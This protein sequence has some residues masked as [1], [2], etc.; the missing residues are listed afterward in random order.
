M[1]RTLI[2]DIKA[3]K[4]RDPAARSYLEIVLCYSGLHAIL[5]HRVNHW[6]WTHGFKLLAR[7]GSQ[8]AKMF[9]GI[10]IHPGAKIGKGFFIDHGTGTVIGETA[11]I[12]DNVTLFHGVTLGGTGK[13][14]GK[15]H[16][17]VEDNV[18]VGA[19]AQVLGSFTIGEGSVIGAGAVV[20]ESVPPN[21][22]VVGPKAYIVRREGKRVYDFRHD[23]LPRVTDPALDCLMLRVQ[24]LEQALA[25]TQRSLEDAQARTLAG[26]TTSAG[27][28]AASSSQDTSEQS[29]LAPAGPKWPGLP[30]ESAVYRWQQRR[31][32]RAR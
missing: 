16:P 14:R 9:T 27:A 13:E 17:T 2:E 28:G 20:V 4:E 5:A 25:E 30:P 1:F 24:K 8:L 3:A 11:E 18:L 6:L 21:C 19:H 32:T 31:N 22:T 10:E 12:G 7:F 23:K 15:R 29:D 26:H